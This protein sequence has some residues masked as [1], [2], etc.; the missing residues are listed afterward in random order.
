MK[1][2]TPLPTS[3]L[4]TNPIDQLRP[5]AR[6]VASDDQIR[7]RAAAKLTGQTHNDI[8][9]VVLKVKIWLVTSAES[10]TVSDLTFEALDVPAT[11]NLVGSSATAENL[12]GCLS[13]HQVL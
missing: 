2:L 3:L 1:L 8:N 9:L 10:T 11:E 13:F 6:Q 5:R 4:S 7:Q 12:F